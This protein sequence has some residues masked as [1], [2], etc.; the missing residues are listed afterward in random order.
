LA[1][2]QI[3]LFQALV[4]LG[5]TAF[6]MSMN[7]FFHLNEPFGTG[8]SSAVWAVALLGCAVPL[9]FQVRK[10]AQETG[11]PR[12]LNAL[13]L[14]VEQPMFFVPV[15]LLAV[16]LFIKLFGLKLTFAWA[17]EGFAVF[18]LALWAKERSFRLTGLSLLALSITK[19]AYDTW[20]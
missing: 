6:R 2:R 14:H 7:N 16:L 18:A 15:V 11:A 1:G 10:N 5:V 17:V 9:A 12:W 13:V 8:L 3:F 20:Y 4:M 19:L